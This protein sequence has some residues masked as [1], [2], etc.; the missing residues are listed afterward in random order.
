MTS[1]THNNTNNSVN[2]Q[3]LALHLG[4]VQRKQKTKV[5]GKPLNVTFLA[6][7]YS[8]KE[9]DRKPELA[10]RLQNIVDY[11]DALSKACEG[12]PYKFTRRE[13]FLQL[14]EKEIEKQKNSLTS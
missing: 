10:K 1:S 8:Q 5:K 7:T 4:L 9:L 12:S 13:F 2:P 14:L 11:F 3:A 6:L